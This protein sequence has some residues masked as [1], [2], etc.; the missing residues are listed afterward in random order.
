MFF[1]GSS[2]VLLVDGDADV[3]TVPVGQ[4]GVGR[5][6]VLV[7]AEGEVLTEDPE[8]GHLATRKRTRMTLR[9]FY[10]FVE[11]A[12]ERTGQKMTVDS[13]EKIGRKHL[14][15]MI[16]RVSNFCKTS[17]CLTNLISFDQL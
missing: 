10:R 12:I 13:L 3:V 11:I 9:V 16:V 15:N 6:E 17:T 7:E 14:W 5:E 4:D 8:E 2:L 1:F